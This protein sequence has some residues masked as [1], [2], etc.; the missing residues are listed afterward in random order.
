M[1]YAKSCPFL[2]SFMNNYVLMDRLRAHFENHQEDL[3]VQRGLLWVDTSKIYGYKPLPETNAR[4]AL[5]KKHMFE[6]YKSHLYLWVPPSMPYYPLEGVYR[7]SKGFSKILLFS[8]WEMVPRM[9][10]SLISYEAERLT[11]GEISHN[12]AKKDRIYII[13]Q[14]IKDVILIVVYRGAVNGFCCIQ[15]KL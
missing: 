10:G 15:V 7:D 6:Q 4:L 9:I 13:I 1:D 5:L 3:P 2:L 11:V 12:A 14:R 8:A